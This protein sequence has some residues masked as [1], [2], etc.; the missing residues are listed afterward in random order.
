MQ[1]V[2]RRSVDRLCS[3]RFSFLNVAFFIYYLLMLAKRVSEGSHQGSEFDTVSCIFKSIIFERC[4]KLA[5]I[6]RRV[7]DDHQVFLACFT[8]LVRIQFRFTFSVKDK[9]EATRMRILT[10]LI[11]PR[12]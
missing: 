10:C 2:L 3:L 9:T 4:L 1:R 12:C 6:R 11:L 7:P 5:Q 8:V